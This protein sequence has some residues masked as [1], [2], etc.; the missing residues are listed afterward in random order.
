MKTNRL[1]VFAGIS[2]L[3]GISS[4]ASRGATVISD[5][6]GSGW[7][8]TYSDLALVSDPNQPAGQLNVEK[9]ATFT[10]ADAGTGLLITFTQTSAKATPL[11]DFTDES[12]TNVTGQTW[13]GFDFI[14]LNS[15]GNA[16]F[17]TGANTPFAAPAGIFTTEDSTTLDGN[18]AVVYSGGTQA[19]L[20]TSLWGI[21]ADGDLIIDADPLGVGTSFTFKEV[22]V[23]GGGG[24]DN[25][26]VPLPA[27]V[28]QGLSGLAML[29]L[30][31]VA[32]RRTSRA[33]H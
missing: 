4:A 8:A 32:K 10:T 24:P 22:P 9:A 6:G 23:I 29:G 28:W 26:P 15:N 30:I 5:I 12:V 14:L 25:T 33:A 3:L 31:A 13:S 20:A 19:N 17:A 2:A 16:S 27:A 21:G 11:I 18:P 1:L 7:T